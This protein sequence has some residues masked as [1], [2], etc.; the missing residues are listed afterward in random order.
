MMDA[1]VACVEFWQLTRWWHDGQCIL[2]TKMLMTLCCNTCVI[3]WASSPSHTYTIEY[4]HPFSFLRSFLHQIF[5]LRKSRMR[6]G[7][8]KKKMNE[9]LGEKLGS[10]KRRWR[11]QSRGRTRVRC[12]SVNLW[13]PQRGVGFTS[14]RPSRRSWFVIKEAG[15][16][17]GLV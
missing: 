13:C 8:A 9:V 12:R 16:Q 17:I 1:H 7:K 10:Y 11:S 3:S 14:V 2:G 4:I 5:T 6:K 15:L